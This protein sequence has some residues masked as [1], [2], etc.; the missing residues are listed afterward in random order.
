MLFDFSNFTAK[1]SELNRLHKSLHEL[2]DL[3]WRTPKAED[4][5]ERFREQ[6]L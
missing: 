4:R 2:D 6:S 3:P 5:D 1:V